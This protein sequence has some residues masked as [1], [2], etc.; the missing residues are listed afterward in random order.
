[1]LCSRLNEAQR[2]CVKTGCIVTRIRSSVCPSG[3]RRPR[4]LHGLLWISAFGKDFGD[5]PFTTTNKGGK[6]YRSVVRSAPSRGC[7]SC[8]LQGRRAAWQTLRSD[9]RHQSSYLKWYVPGSLVSH[10]LSPEEVE[11][12]E[13]GEL[14]IVSGWHVIDPDCRTIVLEGLADSIQEICG[15]IPRDAIN[16]ESLQITGGSHS[17]IHATS[18]HAVQRRPEEDSAATTAS[19]TQRRLQTST[20]L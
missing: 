1:M 12:A 9:G 4:S 3:L 16:D 18:L 17:T 19:S 13:S 6:T 14:D 15:A 2:L 11:A 20:T 10:Q 7:A 5:Q 8:S